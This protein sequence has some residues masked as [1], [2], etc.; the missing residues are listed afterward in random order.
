[1]VHE[2]ISYELF[3]QLCNY[4]SIKFISLSIIKLTKQVF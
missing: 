1:M 2:L 3:K 4:L